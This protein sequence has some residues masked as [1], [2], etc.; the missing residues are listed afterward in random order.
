MAAQYIPKRRIQREA[1]PAT[2]SGKIQRFRLREMLR[3][4]GLSR[5]M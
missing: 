4:A 5:M 1:T 3:R 2:P